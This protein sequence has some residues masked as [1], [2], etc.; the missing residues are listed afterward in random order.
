MV[1][2]CDRRLTIST[3]PVLHIAPSFMRLK[4]IFAKDVCDFGASISRQVLLVDGTSAY[5]APQKG[6]V[7]HTCNSII[8]PTQPPPLY[9]L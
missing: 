6:A 2:V 8:L 1:G 4:S 7:L 5:L 3:Y 9:N